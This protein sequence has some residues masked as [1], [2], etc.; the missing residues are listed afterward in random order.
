MNRMERLAQERA[1][2][3]RKRNKLLM[4]IGAIV[5]VIALVAGIVA[6]VSSLRSN[7]SQSNASGMRQIESVIP[8]DVDG[9]FLTENNKAAWEYMEAIAGENFGDDVTSAQYIGVALR[10]GKP[11]FYL[12]G[13]DSDKLMGDLYDRKMSIA[14]AG[15]G[16]F[17]VGTDDKTDE[18]DG[19]DKDN[20]LAN[21]ATYKANRPKNQRSV[22]YL[23]S[24]NMTKLPPAAAG[25]PQTKWTWQGTFTDG[26]WKGN[27]IGVKASD[28]DTTKFAQWIAVEKKADWYNDVLSKKDDGSIDISL[29]ADNLSTFTG[30]P[31]YHT[32][33]ADIKAN[34]TNDGFMFISLS[35]AA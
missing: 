5:V 17:V 1:T 20:P 29:D 27:I 22:A 2:R 6:L 12:Q 31:K 15:N 28:F 30:M 23:T 18:N 10:D 13:S 25:F 24:K 34:I 9:A 11:Y 35:K 21:D 4:I 7:K 33:I 19:I 16:V 32:D 14:E 3:K 8:A 26:Q